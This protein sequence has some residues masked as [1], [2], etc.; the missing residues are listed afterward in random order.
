MLDLETLATSHNSVV[1]TLGATKFNPFTLQDP[2]EDLYLRL[3]VDDQMARGRDVDER[4]VEW[5][6]TQPAA[7][8]DEAL[9]PD[10]RVAVVDVLQQ[11]NKFL[12]GAD[13][14]WCQGPHFDITILESL[15]KQYEVPV[16]W[17]FWQVMDSRT[18]FGLFGDPRDKNAAGLHNA[19]EDCKSQARG[20]QKL[21]KE[22][23]ITK[24][25]NRF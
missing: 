8:Q 11:L 6:G 4:T 15:Y 25:A 7:V 17:Q 1:L 16:N 9:G 24:Y 13:K 14:I 18:L 2:F 5:W 22:H 19:L 21:F 3:E 20:V 12:V 23:S 10:N